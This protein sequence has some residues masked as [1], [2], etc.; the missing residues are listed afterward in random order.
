[1]EVTNVT[2]VSFVNFMELNSSTTANGFS[3]YL[4]VLQDLV[5]L[6]VRV[7]ILG[8]SSSGKYDVRMANKTMDVCKFFTDRKYVP[9]AQVFY[10]A[11]AKN[12]TFPKSCPIRKV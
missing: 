6:N 9:I 8:E 2:T 7:Q 11:F 10:R 5:N 12:G 3:I 1:M 4:H